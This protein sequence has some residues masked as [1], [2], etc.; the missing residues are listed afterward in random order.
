MISAARLV[1]FPGIR[2]HISIKDFLLS[3]LMRR[4]FRQ[5]KTTTVT[6]RPQ[7]LFQLFFRQQICKQPLFTRFNFSPQDVPCAIYQQLLRYFL[8]WVL[9]RYQT[10]NGADAT[11]SR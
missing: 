4:L 5:I 8:L 3:R 11:A 2:R 6:T 10:Y 9:L 1:C 7:Q